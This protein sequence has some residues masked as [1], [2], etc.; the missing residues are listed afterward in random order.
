[1]AR[2]LAD[3]RALSRSDH[4]SIVQAR[5]Y[6]ALRLRADRGLAELVGWACGATRRAWVRGVAMWA[7][8]GAAV[9]SF[10]QGRGKA[11]HD[12]SAVSGF[13]FCSSKGNS[14]ECRSILHK[15]IYFFSRR[16]SSLEIAPI[17]PTLVGSG[18]RKKATRTSSFPGEAATIPIAS[19]DESRFGFGGPVRRAV[20][21]R[22]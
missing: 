20:V 2:Y 6:L 10:R 16:F 15:D 18:W 19:I 14:L 13:V 12:Y 7:R 5:A 1:M 21:D 8:L 9:V 3:F 17:S 11:A 22:P 4:E